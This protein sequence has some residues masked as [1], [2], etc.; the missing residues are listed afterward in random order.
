MKRV[1]R[2]RFGY[3][4]LDEILPEGMSY[5]T[6]T[7]ISGPGGTGKPLVGFAFISSWLKNG[8]SI[9]LISIQYKSMDFI[10]ITT[11]ELYGLDLDDYKDR[12][13]YVQFNP[14]IDSIERKDRNYL[15]A[16]LLKPENWDRTINIA[17]EIK[18]NRNPGMLIF[19]SALNILLFSPTYRELLLS[20]IGEIL[21]KEKSNTYVF[22]VSTSA[23][24]EEIA[25]WEEKSDNLIMTRMEKPMRLFLKI[26]R[27]KDVEFLKKEIEVPASK[28]ML[29]KIKEVSE[30][31]RNRIIPMLSK[32]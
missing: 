12:I 19:A 7:L 8:G 26:L 23:F 31:S 17:T 14:D 25:N 15:E 32:M 30:S 11:K 4:W 1:N 20:K 29:M 3:E 6:S 13:L 18:K 24:K 21:L 5:P 22:T 10:K 2:I 27:M 16:N 9:V 28:Q